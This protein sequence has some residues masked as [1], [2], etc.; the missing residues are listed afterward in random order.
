M[1]YAHCTALLDRLVAVNPVPFADGNAVHS[2]Y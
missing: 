1:E 2:A